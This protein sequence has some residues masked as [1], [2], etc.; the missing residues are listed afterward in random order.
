VVRAE[1]G[2]APRTPDTTLLHPEGERGRGGGGIEG[3]EL[4]DCYPRPTRTP[5]RTTSST[6][7]PAPFGSTAGT[8]EMAGT[9]PKITTT[10]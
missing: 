9:V 2:T 4:G 1:V 3:S 10:P 7:R 8:R 6:D 5:A